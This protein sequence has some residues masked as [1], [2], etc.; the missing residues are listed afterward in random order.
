MGSARVSPIDA[1]NLHLTDANLAKTLSE[2]ILVERISLSILR[3]L[4]CALLC[5][6]TIVGV[7]AL[8]NPSTDQLNDR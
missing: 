8:L 5:A 3:S 4:P 6:T 1:C 7:Q 2:G